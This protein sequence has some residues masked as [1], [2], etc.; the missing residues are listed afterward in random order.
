[1]LKRAELLASYARREVLRPEQCP[2]EPLAVVTRV[3]TNPEALTTF[4]RDRVGY[5]P[6]LGVVR[7]ARG[8]LAAGAGGDWDRALLLQSL[9]AEAG[10]RSRFIVLQRTDEE[11]NPVVQSFLEDRSG[12]LEF[13]AA[14]FAVGPARD[15]L[16]ASIGVRVPAGRSA[17]AARAGRWQCLLDECYDAGAE[18]VPR[19][20]A[21]LAEAGSRMG[22]DFEAWRAILV[23][24]ARERVLIELDRDSM[25]LDP[26]PDSFPPPPAPCPK[27]LATPSRRR[28]A[29]PVSLS[30]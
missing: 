22:Q 8:T 15:R 30:R 7:G 14:R 4:V 10:F 29:G 16:A 17:E 20:G 19:L 2:F 5:E 26:S 13:E 1:M 9:L 11:L 12:P 18:V 24:G 6:I 28:S 25:V 23:S 21:T 27:Q 3:G